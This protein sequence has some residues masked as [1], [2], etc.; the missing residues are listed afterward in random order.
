M[1]TA[2]AAVIGAVGSLAAGAGVLVAN[3][4]L[5]RLIRRVD[6]VEATLRTLMA[7][8]VARPNAK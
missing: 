5:D 3:S 4:K 6:A 7:R 8:L 1:A 2:V